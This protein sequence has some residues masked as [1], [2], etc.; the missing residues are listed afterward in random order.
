VPLARKT[1][2][3]QK[4]LELQRALR[5][6]RDA[7]DRYHQMA[8]SGLITDESVDAMGYPPDLE[9]LVEGV[10]VAGKLE[11][12]RFLRRI[13]RDPMTGEREW[14]L[15]SYQDDW[16]STSW[17]RENV[18]DVYSLSTGVALDGSEYQEW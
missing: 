17:G 5:I 14:G 9:A 12:I 15:R 10:H 11:K 7:I 6:M 18:F 13:P 8:E 16:D 3:R 1:V 2:Q 4:E